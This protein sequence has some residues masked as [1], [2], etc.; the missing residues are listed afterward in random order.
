MKLA[1][2]FAVLPVAVAL[3]ACGGAEAPAVD[4][5]KEAAAMALPMEQAYETSRGALGFANPEYDTDDGTIWDGDWLGAARVTDLTG[6]N[7]QTSEI[8]LDGVRGVIEIFTD[9][10]RYV[11]ITRDD[12]DQTM[13]SY[14]I[15]ADDTHFEVHP[16]GGDE[17]YYTVWPDL[18]IPG[19]KEDG[20]VRAIQP[21]ELEQMAAFFVPDTTNRFVLRHR[22]V[23]P[24]N[25]GHAY[26]VWYDMKRVTD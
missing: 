10:M 4:P 23:N 3:V 8:N 24:E 6:P 22:V 26:T 15:K 12:I 14:Y 2:I 25:P 18:G 7:E 13:V 11:E 5:D 9:G 1:R 20:I 17:N 16:A 21:T 19:D